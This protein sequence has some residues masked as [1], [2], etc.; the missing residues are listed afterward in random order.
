MRIIATLVLILCATPSTAACAH[1]AETASFAWT[2]DGATLVPQL[3]AVGWY[4]LGLWR[5]ARERGLS[6]VEPGRVLSFCGGMAILFLAL[7]SPLDTMADDLLSAHMAQHMLLMLAVPP[8]LVWS[9]PGLIFFRAFPRAARK[10]LGQFWTAAG[11]SRGA[12]WLRHP[13][14]AWA[15]FCGAFVFWHAPGPYTAA[16]H[17]D[18]LHALEHVTLL[19]AS[20]AFWSVVV[21]ARG[22]RH[23][24]YGATIL[25]VTGTAVLSDFPGA[26]MI[27]APRLMY[28][29]HDAG[30]AAWGLTPMQ[31][32]Q[33]AGLLM[34][35]PGGLAY[36]VAIGWLFIAWLRHAEAKAL[37][38]VRHLAVNVS[39]LACF[40]FLL[41]ACGRAQRQQP[42]N[43]DGNAERG[44]T[45]IQQFGCGGCHTI[46]RVASADG[47]VGPPLTRIGS[48]IYIAGV[49]RNS[50]DNLAM[51]IRDPQNIVPG[52]AMPDMNIDR[53]DSRDIAA[54]LSTLK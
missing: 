44:R 22:A 41:C 39:V 10:A 35:I 3:V 18:A 14:L 9:D 49:L 31:D 42:L 13:L 19:G 20:L 7:Q 8:L 6:T 40:C 2:W 11:L 5:A 24:G 21:P 38:S 23:L 25:F 12:N 30:P 32:Q 1:E 43:F 26:L 28:P 16:L 34:W 4:G 27:F 15:A 37:T 52:N 47:N 36:L 17:V 29:V 54:F 48:R 33:L 50:P 45:L 51:W 46:P 53:R